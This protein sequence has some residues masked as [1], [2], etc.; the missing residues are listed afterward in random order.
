MWINHGRQYGSLAIGDNEIYLFR[1]VKKRRLNKQMK[2]L[3]AISKKAS[4]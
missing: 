2:R 1:G 4:M 3:E